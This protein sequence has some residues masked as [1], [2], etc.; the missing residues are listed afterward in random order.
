M[1]SR[2]FIGESRQGGPPA[3]SY[4]AQA[5]AYFEES[6]AIFRA[7][8]AQGAVAAWQNKLARVALSQGDVAVAGAQAEESLTLHREVGD[9]WGAGLSLNT[10]GRVVQARGDHEAAVAQFAESLHLLF[11]HGARRSI[12]E[13]LEDLASSLAALG[14]PDRAARMLGVAEA[15][16][17][18]IG[19]H[20]PAAEE[21]AHRRTVA[22]ARDALGS[23]TFD[24]AR[25]S[26]QALPL[27]QAISEVIALADEITCTGAKQRT[28]E[29]ESNTR[30]R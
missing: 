7:L 26:G 11:E 16:S 10:L 19:A 5:R 30:F 1:G 18:E 9:A 27:P 3:R 15:L 29:S 20:R 8:G 24:A 22:A 13:G 28:D 21:A 25:R 23:T 12:A 2:C 6:L 4:D 17:E 14:K